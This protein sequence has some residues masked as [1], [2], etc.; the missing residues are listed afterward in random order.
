MK[1]PRNLN[2]ADLAAALIRHWDYVHV[3]QA[4]T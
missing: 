2:G 4:V 1:T 3:H